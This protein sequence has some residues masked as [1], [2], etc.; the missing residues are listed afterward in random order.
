MFDWHYG[1]AKAV[2]YFLSGA[3]ELFFFTNGDFT[4]REVWFGNLKIASFVE[5]RII[6]AIFLSKPRQLKKKS[7]L[8][9]KRF[10]KKCKEVGLVGQFEEQWFV[11]LFSAAYF[12]AGNSKTV[13]VN[14]F[15]VRDER[16]S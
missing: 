7:S 4:F 15:Q 16:G 12:L 1:Q 10:C 2:C 8:R 6:P 11:Y 13:G 3:L 14:G 5:Q 9:L